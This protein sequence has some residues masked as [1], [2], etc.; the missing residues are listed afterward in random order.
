M[1]RP[2]ALPRGVDDDFVTSQLRCEASAGT[3]ETFVK[4]GREPRIYFLQKS[5]C[6]TQAFRKGF[7]WP[8]GTSSV[9]FGFAQASPVARV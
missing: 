9:G 7:C 5:T 1:K 8:V 6:I 3:D 2:G 4:L